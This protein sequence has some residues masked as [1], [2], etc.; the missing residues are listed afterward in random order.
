MIEIKNLTVKYQDTPIYENF[1]LLIE[2]NKVTCILG[3]SGSGKTTLLNA[4]AGLIN[5]QGEITK[6]RCS[7]VFQSPNLVKNLTVEENLLL[8]NEDVEKVTTMLKKLKILDK[9]KSYPKHLSGGERKRC[10]IARALVFSAPT[11]LLDEPF[12]SLDLK[13]KYEIISDLLLEQKEN[14][15]TVIFVTHD[16]KEAVTLAD[17]II[18]VKGGLVKAEFNEISK[19]TE[20][21]IFDLMLKI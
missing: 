12:S 15:R 19:N 5:Y 1:N 9:A 2:E 6:T 18:L 4:I 7:Y 10:A 3:E 14:P 13:V 17:K 16:V 8:V 21:E 11:L 20:K